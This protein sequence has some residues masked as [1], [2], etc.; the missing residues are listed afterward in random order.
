MIR[1]VFE[2][3]PEE[4]DYPAIR[5]VN[6]WRGVLSNPSIHELSEQASPAYHQAEPILKKLLKA[7]IA[8]R[9]VRSIQYPMKVARLP[10]FRDRVGFDFTQSDVNEALV[11]SLH[12]GEFM[13]SA[14]NVVFVSSPGTG[15]THLATAITV[16]AIQYHHKRIRYLSAIELVNLLE[17]EKQLGRQGRMANRLIHTDLVIKE[18]K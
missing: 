1:S 3:S 14:Q 6:I 11:T 5:F 10:S 13:E 2:K 12:H 7:E 4:Q 18:K 16:Q 17:Q 15:K 9:E 8:E